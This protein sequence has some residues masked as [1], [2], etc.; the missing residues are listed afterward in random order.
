MALTENTFWEQSSLERSDT[1]DELLINNSSKKYIHAHKEES[2]NKLIYNILIT[3]MFNTLGFDSQKNIFDI[4]ISIIDKI[5]YFIDKDDHQTKEWINFCYN[6]YNKVKKTS[7]EQS[8]D[9]FISSIYIS[10]QYI[11]VN[12]TNSTY[13][14]EHDWYDYVL[15]DLSKIINKKTQSVSRCILL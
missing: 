10:C 7:K 1:E 8:M 6:L 12:E 11:F 5:K 3:R 15:Y 2:I 4:C 13:A 14:H 9:Y